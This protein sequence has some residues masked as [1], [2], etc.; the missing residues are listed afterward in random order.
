[1][2]LKCDRLAVCE[3]KNGLV[4]AIFLIQKIVHIRILLA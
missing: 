4:F 1:M 3:H 2:I